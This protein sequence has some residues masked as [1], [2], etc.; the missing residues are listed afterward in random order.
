MKKAVLVIL[1]GWGLAPAGPGNAISL[2]NTPVVDR[3]MNECPNTTLLTSGEDVGLPEGQMGNSEVGHLNIGAGR[4]VWQE[5]A[6]INKA[7]REKTFDSQPVLVKA[8]EAAKKNNSKLHFIG[9]VS[10][11]GVHSHINH[12]KQLCTVANSYGLD[13][14]F[15]HAFTDGRDTDPKGGLGYLNELQAHLDQSTGKIASV[16]GR[17]YAMDRDKR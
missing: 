7:I 16:T 14:V 13:K 6:N 11:G 17:Y 10:D 2:A 4:I 8:F 15:V 3:L 5:L 9:L 12:L 1:D